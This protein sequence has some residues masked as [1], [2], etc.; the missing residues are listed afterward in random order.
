MKKIFVAKLSSFHRRVIKERLP[1]K[2]D[3][4]VRHL[5]DQPCDQRT[6]T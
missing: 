1:R 6:F 5:G 4:Q 3:F 2:D